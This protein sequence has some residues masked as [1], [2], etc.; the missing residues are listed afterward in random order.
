MAD[1]FEPHGE[2]SSWYAESVSGSQ[3]VQYKIPDAI[4]R[5]DRMIMT[6]L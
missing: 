3:E 6:I 4:L 2:G 1:F 5:L